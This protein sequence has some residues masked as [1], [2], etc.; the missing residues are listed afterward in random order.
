MAE[1]SKKEHPQGEHR[2]VAR[3]MRFTSHAGGVWGAADRSSSDTPVVHRHDDFEKASEDEI[4]AFEV[5]RDHGHAYIY[6]KP[7]NS[8]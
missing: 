3:M 7:P 1:R 5:Q 4:A 2:M 8:K 6:R